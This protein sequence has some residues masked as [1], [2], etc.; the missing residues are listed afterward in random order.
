MGNSLVVKIDTFN[1]NQYCHSTCTLQYHL[2]DPPIMGWGDPEE[3][4]TYIAFSIK[5]FLQ[6]SHYSGSLFPYLF[7]FPNVHVKINVRTPK[8]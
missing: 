7:L 3:N 1:Y 4:P 5:T 6:I 2:L 8:G